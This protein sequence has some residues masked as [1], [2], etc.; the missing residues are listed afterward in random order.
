MQPIVDGL[1]IE[2]QERVEFQRINASTN[3]GIEIFNTYSLFGH[4]SFLILDDDGNILW[5]GVG[6]Q[7]SGVIEGALLKGLE[8]L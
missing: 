3:A 4:P 5:Q 2:Y 7:D 8:S 1:E 6:E